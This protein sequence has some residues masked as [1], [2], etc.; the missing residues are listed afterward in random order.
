VVQKSVLSRL[1]AMQG[2]LVLIAA[3]RADQI[4]AEL[5]K[6]D[7]EAGVEARPPQAAY[8]AGRASPPPDREVHQQVIVTD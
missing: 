4:G 2:A 6:P 5:A 7:Y 8:V 3:K 1:A